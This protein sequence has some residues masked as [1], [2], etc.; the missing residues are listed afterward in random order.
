MLRLL[1]PAF[2]LT[3]ALL[4]LFAGTVGDHLASFLTADNGLRIPAP[5]SDR[6]TLPGRSGTPDPVS[7]AAPSGPQTMHPDATPEDLQRQVQT[8]QQEAS[9]LQE[10]LARR[11]QE[12]DQRNQ[13]LESRTHDIKLAQTQAD[14]L[15]LQV[16]TS[17]QNRQA[18]DMA[19]PQP[20][21]N[22]PALDRQAQVLDQHRGNPQTAQA[23]G[24]R[25]R[26]VIEN[27]RQQDKAQEANPGRQKTEATPAR[28]EAKQQQQHFSR[29]QPE[30][31][32]L[33]KLT[34]QAPAP[35]DSPLP[36]QRLMTARQWL[37]VGRPDEARRLLAMVQTQL[38]LQPVTP[39]A[40]AARGA[41]APAAEVGNALRWLDLGAGRQAMQAINQAIRDSSEPAGV[42][43]AWSGYSVGAY[44]GTYQG[45]SQATSQPYGP[46]AYAPT[47]PR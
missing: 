28:Q 21:N 26:Q 15:R 40:P 31:A 32:A 12:L 34:P 44:S 6:P 37:A 43:R 13:E 2:A 19:P 24:E 4:V 39:D 35:A 18:D 36:V 47:D 9:A 22:S 20:A 11:S 46:E 45:T 27:L 38:V 7:A 33:L 41:S 42:V 23:D 5:P 25:L 30:P 29:A 8:L 16:E 10:Q 3:T 14:N 1:L 17:R